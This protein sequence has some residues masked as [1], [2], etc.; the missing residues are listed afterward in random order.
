[1]LDIVLTTKILNPPKLRALSLSLL[2]LMVN[3]CL[4]KAYL[5]KKVVRITKQ[6]CLV[7]Y[8]HFL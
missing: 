6:V 3:L 7:N 4:T 5:L 8:V 2:S 1:M